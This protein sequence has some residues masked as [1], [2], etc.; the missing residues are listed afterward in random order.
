VDRDLPLIAPKAPERVSCHPP[1]SLWSLTAW[2]YLA[3][4][5]S[6]PDV[7]LAEFDYTYAWSRKLTRSY[8]YTKTVLYTPS[9]LT[10]GLGCHPQ[11]GDLCVPLLRLS[12][13]QLD[14][15]LHVLHDGTAVSTYTLETVPAEDLVDW[16][17]Q[18]RDSHL[19]D[20]SRF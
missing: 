5:W 1:T 18:V 16:Q 11:V 9:A 20:E 8:S 15:I 7:G 3:S 6:I 10:Y 19:V 4:I 14:L 12:V 2:R 17:K 13:L